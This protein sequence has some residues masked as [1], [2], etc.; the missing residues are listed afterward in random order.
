MHGL[1]RWWRARSIGEQRFLI[2]VGGLA[3]LAT[4]G[5]L[6]IAT[7]GAILISGELMFAVGGAAATVAK[8]LRR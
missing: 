4:G 1:V 3:L 8:N 2:A 7:R 5:G 6:A